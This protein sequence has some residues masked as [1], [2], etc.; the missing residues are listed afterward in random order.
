[1][2]NTFPPL[3]SASSLDSTGLQQMFGNGATSSCVVRV[4]DN[5]IFFN[6][7][8]GLTG[9]AY[10]GKHYTKGVEDIGIFSSWATEGRGDNR[11][12]VVEFPRE[13][14]ILSSATSLTIF[15]Q[16]SNPFTV[17]MSFIQGN[18]NAFLDN[19]A[20]TRDLD[21]GVTVFNS[22]NKTIIRTIGSWPEDGVKAGDLVTL[23]G[24]VAN[25]KTV[26]VVGYMPGANSLDGI[27]VE[28]TLVDAT[29][30]GIVTIYPY[31]RL[32][33]RAIQYCCG[34]VTVSFVPEEGSFIEANVFL[35]LDFVQDQAYADF[36]NYY[37]STNLVDL[38][39][40]NGFYQERRWLMNQTKPLNAV[41][42]FDITYIHTTPNSFTGRG[43]WTAPN[44][45][46]PYSGS[47]TF[48]TSY[49]DVYVGPI[50]GSVS[51]IP[52]DD[53]PLYRV[54]AFD[55]PGDNVEYPTLPAYSVID[56]GGNWAITNAYAG[57]KLAKLVRISDGVIIAT[58]DYPA[59]IDPNYAV[60]I[61]KKTD[62][63]YY[64]D[65]VP[66]LTDQTWSTGNRPWSYLDGDFTARLV[67]AAGTPGSRAEIT[68]NHGGLT[69]SYIIPQTDP[70]Y[71]PLSN[72]CYAYDQ[73]VALI[74][75]LA[76][77]GQDTVFSDLLAEWLI[78]AQDPTSKEWF[79]SFDA[80]TGLSPDPYYRTG[81]HAWACYALLLYA[82]LFPSGQ[83]HDAAKV[84][85]QNGL[86][87]LL[88]DKV[89]V[90]ASE[91][92]SGGRGVYENDV[93]F[94]DTLDWVS[95]EHNIDC[96]FALQAGGVV[97]SEPSYLNESNSL[98]VAIIE[99]LWNPEASRFY[100]GF[101]GTLDQSDAL[102]I[103]TWGAMFL[104]AAG[105]TD[106]AALALVNAFAFKMTVGLV[107][108]YVPYLPDRGYPNTSPSP[109][110]EGTFQYE[111]AA[112]KF[113][114]NED[115]II[116]LNNGILP[117]RRPDYGW[118][119]SQLPDTT[120]YVSDWESVAGTAWAIIANEP[121]LYAVVLSPLPIPA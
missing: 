74:A 38:L 110:S 23:S 62:I 24:F 105:D 114:V 47:V 35:H 30:S 43:T 49:S 72:R 16:S 7:I 18:M 104:S 76:Y 25:N 93:F 117:N 54:Y 121:S 65:T 41:P 107:T 94:N 45:V 14:V 36:S 91:L 100:Q 39:N 44:Y 78:K 8:L 63:D 97:L 96:Y 27:I 119:Y 20:P 15:D 60:E 37:A 109:W 118:A 4:E 73:A 3:I 81:A 17:W 69:R 84:A 10:N 90:G 113:G 22:A 56:P 112:R 108:G 33:P 87:R 58:S 6:P 61:W 103:N 1:M 19:F 115:L 106:K 21:T 85:A 51:G 79:F 5:D 102:D 40:W 120:T 57:Y 52:V 64:I 13:S 80:T 26:T 9:F 99:E 86:N 66:A 55:I 68:R 116:N 28:E 111:L 2:V 31:S 95:T 98:K 83:F 48:S 67:A 46:A 88:M 50:S 92:I 34:R 11:G 59:S 42:G 70:A 32:V 29:E 82:Y 71:A 12:S 53:Y 77:I 101:N 75:S 89:T